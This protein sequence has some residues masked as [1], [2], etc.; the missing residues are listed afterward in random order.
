[1]CL[2]APRTQQETLFSSPF[3]FWRCNGSLHSKQLLLL[4][5]P[6]TRPHRRRITFKTIVRICCFWAS[7]K[8]KFFI[9]L[10]AYRQTN[11]PELNFSVSVTGTTQSIS[12]ITF[13]GKI[14][15]NDMRRFFKSVF[16]RP[17]EPELGSKTENK[18]G[19]VEYSNQ[20]YKKLE[21]LLHTDL[22]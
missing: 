22:K 18:K 11:K 4:S 2:R 10:Y 16:D 19:S 5:I 9:K 21:K 8:I 12:L 13:P 6:N 15:V 17:K 3:F 20:S 1:M 14:F 7:A